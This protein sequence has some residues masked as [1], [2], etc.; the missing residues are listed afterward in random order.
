M[1]QAGEKPK[2]GQVYV[3]ASW[4]AV[5]FA[6]TRDGDAYGGEHELG[7]TKSAS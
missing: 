7:P 5:C 4:G 6:P 3:Q 2:R 1:A